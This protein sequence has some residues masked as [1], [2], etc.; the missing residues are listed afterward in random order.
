MDA[1]RCANCHKFIP[2]KEMPSFEEY[3]PPIGSLNYY[4]KDCLK[5]L[6]KQGII[7]IKQRR[8]TMMDTQKAVNLEEI[9]LESFICKQFDI[10]HERFLDIRNEYQELHNT[11]KPPMKKVILKA[12]R[13]TWNHR[14]KNEEKIDSMEELGRLIL[15]ECDIPELTTIHQSYSIREESVLTILLCEDQPMNLIEFA[16]FKLG[17]SDEKIKDNAVKYLKVVEAIKTLQQ[18]IGWAIEK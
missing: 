8:D 1:L 11:K 2:D 9:C 3:S 16:G 15:S 14:F 7:K 18:Y 17:L 4:C 6:Q 12:Y 13:P 10:S 5:D